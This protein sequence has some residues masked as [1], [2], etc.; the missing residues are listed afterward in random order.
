MSRGP[1]SE[2]PHESPRPAVAVSLDVGEAGQL[3]GEPGAAVQI[4]HFA[5]RETW[6]GRRSDADRPGHYADRHGHAGGLVNPLGMRARYPE[7]VHGIHP[8]DPRRAIP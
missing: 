6:A 7:A 2:A 1:G 8:L 4:V 3:L 5:L